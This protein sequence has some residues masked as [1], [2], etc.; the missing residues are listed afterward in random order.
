[1]RLSITAK[2]LV[3]VALLSAALAASSFIALDRLTAL[4]TAASRILEEDVATATEM[5]SANLA[6]T[7][8]GS[9]AYRLVSETRMD[10]MDKLEAEAKQIGKDLAARTDGIKARMPE[11][12]G[13]LDAALKDFAKAASATERVLDMAFAS[14]Q[15]KALKISSEEVEPALVSARTTFTKVEQAIAGRIAEARSAIAAQADSAR[16]LTLGVAV[17]G[18][19]IAVLLAV[20]I[21]QFGIVR[22]LLRLSGTMRRFAAGD[23]SGVVEGTRRSDELGEMAK[24]VEVFKANGLAM[25]EFKRREAE[26]AAAAADEQ[27]RTLDEL[28]RAFEGSVKSV[29]ATVATTAGRLQTGSSTM[30][31]VARSTNGQVD[32]M[33]HN[34]ESTAE[35]VQGVASATEELAA[36]IADIARQ[37][38]EAS[39]VSTSATAEAE[40]TRDVVTALAERAQRI[41][42]VVGLINEIASQTN[43]LALNATIEAARAGEAGKG[44]AVVAAEVKSLAN[45]TGRATDEIAA[46]V[47]AVQQATR[48]AVSAIA[49][50]V[51]TIG[52]IGNISTSIAGA[53]EQQSAATNEIARNVDAVALAAD[54]LRR[55]IGDVRGAAGATGDAAVDITEA[56]A[57][58]SSQSDL[59]ADAVDQFIDRI[60]RAA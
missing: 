17:G 59:L 42:E 12:A 50:I 3:P 28:A 27:R 25:E 20:A 16:M 56:A 31:E 4:D 46:Q 10:A 30:T 7:R 53:V 21:L 57:N 55:T 5:A 18:C 37:V 33:A 13:D 48:E 47:G 11:A 1:M 24:S 40:R 26:A 14:Q 39:S 35:K 2:A 49:G 38:S 58:L 34:T 36:S 43:L 8:Y 9:I 29:V 6:L 22:P 44:F 51:E 19:L 32:T 45:Q 54:S 15:D 52:R 23:F 41:G 60:R